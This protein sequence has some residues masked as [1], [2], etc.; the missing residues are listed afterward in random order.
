MI[1]FIVIMIVWVIMN[2]SIIF[3]NNI[4]FLWLWWVV[5]FNIDVIIV[6]WFWIIM[7]VYDENIYMF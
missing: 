2:I 6:I 4:V 3:F 5:W 1:K 7:F